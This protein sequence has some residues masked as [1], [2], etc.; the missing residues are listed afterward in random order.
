VGQPEA[1][2]PTAAAVLPLLTG[3][4]STSFALAVW[5]EPAVVTA[6]EVFFDPQGSAV[7]SPFVL[8]AAP[9]VSACDGSRSEV[10][11]PTRQV[12]F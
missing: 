4:I 10:P 11:G 8:R 3:V 7:Y 9:V 5:H 2:R 6:E 12:E 1:G